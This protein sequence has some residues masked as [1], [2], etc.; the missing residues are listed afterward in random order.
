M[1]LKPAFSMERFLR[2]NVVNVV[3]V[4]KSITFTTYPHE[5]KGLVNVV[6][7]V[8]KYFGLWRTR[9]AKAELKS[10]NWA[11]VVSMHWDFFELAFNRSITLSRN[12]S[13]SDLFPVNSLF[14]CMGISETRNP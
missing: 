12:H 4:Y 9:I 6:N 1:M 8:Q 13:I 5:S 3:N 10:L 11:S 7:V 14:L 2:V